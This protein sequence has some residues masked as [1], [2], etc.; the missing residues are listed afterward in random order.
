MIFSFNVCECVSAPFVAVFHILLLYCHVNKILNLQNRKT[1]PREQNLYFFG[2]VF[3]FSSCKSYPFAS[4]FHCFCIL[5]QLILQG[6]SYSFTLRKLYFRKSEE[7]CSAVKLLKIRRLYF[8]HFCSKISVSF[9]ICT[10]F[11]GM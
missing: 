6:E 7:M 5:K 1:V 11:A 2:T 8:S 4:L 3:M 9:Q 10:Y